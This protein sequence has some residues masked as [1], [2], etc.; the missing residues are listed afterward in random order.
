M[1]K[2]K[3]NKYEDDDGRVVAPMN[4]DGM[5]WFDTR[6]PKTNLD[7]NNP[8]PSPEKT[9]IKESIRLVLS[10]YK[11]VLP[12]SLI[13]VAIMAGIIAFLSYVWLK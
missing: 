4:V 2:N 11:I 8:N 13:A 7:E 1:K 3:K 6:T 10:V 12:I 5:P 9:G